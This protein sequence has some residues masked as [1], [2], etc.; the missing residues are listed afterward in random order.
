MVRA[1]SPEMV[2]KSIAVH[3]DLD[4]LAKHHHVI[5]QGAGKVTLLTPAQRATAGALDADSTSFETWLDRLHTLMLVYDGEGLAAARSWLARSGLN[6]DSR[7]HDLVEASLNAVPRSKLKGDFVRPEARILDS[8]RTALFD[9]I[10]V[11]A[12]D[13][14]ATGPTQ[15]GFDEE[16]DED[17][18]AS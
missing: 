7:L 5:K 13:M 12:D 15:L 9:D 2:E 8:L 10:A 6:N 11:P 1:R 3:L 16:S 17:I 14:V 18:D 4:D